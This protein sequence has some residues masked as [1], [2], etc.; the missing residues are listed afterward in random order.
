MRDSQGRSCSVLVLGWVASRIVAPLRSGS[1]AT[2]K[3]TALRRAVGDHDQQL[4]VQRP[5]ER[6]D[7]IMVGQQQREPPFRH[8]RMIMAEA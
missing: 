4:I 1:S 5:G 7:L 6:P 2:G 8:H 3:A